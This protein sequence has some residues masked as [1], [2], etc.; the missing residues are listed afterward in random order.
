MEEVVKIIELCREHGEVLLAEHLRSSVVCTKLNLEKAEISLVIKH[1]VESN[2]ADSLS[3]FL[4]MH[5]GKLWKVSLQSNSG[6][7]LFTLSEIEQRQKRDQVDS[8]LG[9]QLVTEMKRYFENA[10]VTGIYI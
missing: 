7:D 3:G 8:I 6:Q 9:S 10:K 4:E 5:L 1:P 2:F